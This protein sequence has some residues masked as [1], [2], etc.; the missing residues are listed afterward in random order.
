[1]KK[2]KKLMNLTKEKNIKKRLI[3]I[4]FRYIILLALMFSLPI[5]YFILTPLTVYASAGLLNMFYNVSIAQT[6]IDIAGSC[7]SQIQI[8]PSCVAGSAYLLLL[9]L[10]LS[11]SMPKKQR[12][13]SIFFSFSVLFLVN[14]VRIFILS[15]FY[16]N[17]FSFFDITHKLFWYFLSTVFV[18]IIWLLI[19][20]L[21]KIKNIPVYSDLKFVYNQTNFKNN[22]Q[23]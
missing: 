15:I 16:I 11:L 3:F 4:T 19:I 8:I 1:M 9:I 21:F 22:I 6:T 7:L 2:N 5:F 12:F 10:N 18:I 20:K 14:I 17:K 23:S 13:Y